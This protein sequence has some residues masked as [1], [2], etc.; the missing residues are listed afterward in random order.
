MSLKEKFEQIW[1]NLRKGIRIVPELEEEIIPGNPSLQEEDISFILTEHHS[2]KWEDVIYYG[3][4]AAAAEARRR[5]SLGIKDE[6]TPAKPKE[7]KP[8]TVGNRLS[9]L[10]KKRAKLLKEIENLEQK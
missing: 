4:G 2:R 7:A 1:D 3:P 10:I 9:S 5:Q 6:E 8:K